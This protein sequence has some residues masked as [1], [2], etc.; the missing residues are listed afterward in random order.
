MPKVSG[1]TVKKATT[2]APAS[3][4]T[5]KVATTKAKKAAAAKDVYA[6]AA[7]SDPLGIGSVREAR[8]L[9]TLGELASSDGIR[10]ELPIAKLDE[11]TTYGRHAAGFRLD[12]GSVRGM[13]VSARRIVEDDKKGFE[14]FFWSHGAAMQQFKE[15]FETLGAKKSTYNFL[16]A[17]V[18]EGAPA[19]KSALKRKTKT[20]SPSS[21]SALALGTAGK[22][23][24]ELNAGE[25]LALRGAMR[26]RVYGAPAAASKT[27]QDVV[28]KLGLQSALSPST[29]A[30]IERLKLMRFLWQN[31]YDSIRPLMSKPF[32]EVTVDQIETAIGTDGTTQDLKA[33]D[34]AKLD[35]EKVAKRAKLSTLLLK[36]D[37]QAFVTWAHGQYYGQHGILPNASYD[38]GDSG[39]ESAL[40]EAGVK[41]GSAAYKKA[42]GSS[43]AD[44]D[45]ARKAFL[46]GLLAKRDKAAAEGLIARDISEVKP[47]ELET[48]AKAHGLDAKRKAQLRFEE[49]YPGYFT[50][51]DPAQVEELHAAGARYLYSTYDDADRVMSMLQGGQKASLT[52]FSEGLIIEGK[53]S[54]SDFGT[55]GAVAVF[56]RLVTK[57]AVAAGKKAGSGSSWSYEGKFNNWG[58]S[59]PYKI[60]LNKS[61]L[62]RTDWWGF[63]SD[64]FGKSSGLSNKAFGKEL[65]KEIDKNYSSSNELMFPIGNDPAYADFVVC[66]TEDQKKKLVA[67]MKEAGMTEF[68][69]K[70]LS[71]FVRVESHFFDYDA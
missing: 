21:T 34:K 42:V 46:F 52:R 65:I 68:N 62:A 17:D 4:A 19:G 60:I 67:A 48:L 15:R 28:N 8:G 40:E 9:G 1:S 41:S 29:P 32:D 51:V 71:E 44:P 63:N 2:A 3:K 61:V 23:K 37:P 36:H 18:D 56:T 43:P 64:Q 47:A 14:L 22:W 69:G 26:V 59:R 33:I 49:V 12:G 25:P 35:D 66:E 39:L 20:W 7:P 30:S 10:S 13:W 31:A 24:A 11:L 27:L 38:Y 16:A 50:V 55:G 5:K 6:A 53:S 58:G 70:P 54:S 57:S 45:E